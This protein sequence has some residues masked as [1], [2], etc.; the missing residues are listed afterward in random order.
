MDWWRVANEGETFLQTERRVYKERAEKEKNRLPT[1]LPPSTDADA[2][3]DPDAAAPAP[4]DATA[5][6]DSSAVDA[7][8]LSWAKL[9]IIHTCCL[10]FEAQWMSEMRPSLR[11][12]LEVHLTSTTPALVVLT[13]VDGYPP[14]S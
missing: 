5:A 8:A 11:R 13:Y 6:S 2:A 3:A 4:I 12:D 7:S 1:V 10:E 9:E 14:D